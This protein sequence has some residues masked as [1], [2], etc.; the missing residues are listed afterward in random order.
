[1]RSVTV[2][3]AGNEN[4]SEIG[5]GATRRCDWRGV[6]RCS[7]V[8]DSIVGSWVYC[9]WVRCLWVCGFAVRGLV[10]LPFV[11]RGFVQLAVRGFDNLGLTISL[12]VRRSPLFWVRDLSLSLCLR[13]WV[14][15]LSLSLFARLRKWFE[16][17]ILAENIFQVKGLNFTV[18]WNSFPEN[19]FSIRNKTPAFMEK[20]FQKWFEAKT[21]R[22]LIS[23]FFTFYLISKW[24]DNFL[25]K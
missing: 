5:N 20:I 11:V 21:N 9:S 3:L 1:M 7:W 24:Y 14:L 4:E 18:N 17:K 8:R 25:L 10:G 13:V 6:T 2:Q 16:G 12:V 22:A 15:S 23:R 19:P